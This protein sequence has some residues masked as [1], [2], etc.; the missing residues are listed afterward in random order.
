MDRKQHF[1]K[2]YSR[3]MW[4]GLCK[5][6]LWGALAGFGL[7]AICALISYFTGF[8]TGFWI[9]L[10]LLVVGMAGGTPICYFKWYRPSIARNAK[11]LDRLGLEERLVTMIEYEND[12]SYIAQLQREDAK[13]KLAKINPKSIKFNIPKF[14]YVTAASCVAAGVLSSTWLGL[15]NAGLIPNWNQVWHEQILGEQLNRVNIMYEIMGDGE[16]EGDIEQSVNKG[17]NGDVV[18]AVATGDSVFAGWLNML[19][20]VVSKNPVRNEVNVQADVYLFA[21]FMPA[22][23]GEGQGEGDPK[24][25][26]PGDQP[27]KSNQDGKSES[28]NRNDDKSDQG[29]GSSIANNTIINGEEYYG[30]NFDMWHQSA[31]DRLQTGQPLPDGYKQVIENYYDIIKTEKEE[32]EGGN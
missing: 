3:L 22:Q 26:N 13:Q 18:V 7:N 10:G 14:L 23:D 12:D 28:N 32:T 19:G 1:E 17:E 21:A 6:L 15:S 16:I 27:Q 25:G 11:R 31:L 4:E 24:E 8:E 20:M 5:S 2:Y 30:M 9:A 29:G